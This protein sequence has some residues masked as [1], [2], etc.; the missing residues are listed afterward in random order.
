MSDFGY[1]D[2]KLLCPCEKRLQ[3]ML[4]VCNEFGLEYDVN[5]NA[6]KSM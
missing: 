2:L 5:I 1:A 4:K 3:A 6:K